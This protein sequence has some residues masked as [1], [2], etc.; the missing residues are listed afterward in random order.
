MRSG[1]LL[2]DETSNTAACSLLSETECVAQ[3]CRKFI[4]HL[5]LIL[6]SD[7]TQTDR[8]CKEARKAVCRRVEQQ[9][10]TE[11][12]SCNK[13]CVFERK[14]RSDDIKQLKAFKDVRDETISEPQHRH[15]SLDRSA[16]RLSS[17]V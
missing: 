15:R 3:K 9:I 5:A 4:H 8:Q 7:T 17:V 13:L 2:R 11:P 16:Q 6:H 10:H 14:K 1:L 12:N